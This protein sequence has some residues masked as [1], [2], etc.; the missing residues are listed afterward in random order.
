MSTDRRAFLLRT[1]GTLG[2]GALIGAGTAEAARADDAPPPAALPSTGAA[3]LDARFPFDGPHQ[4]GILTPQ[5]DAVTHLALDAIAADRGALIQGL[6]SLSARARELSQGTT[7]AP[8]LSDVDAPPADSGTLGVVVAPDALTVTIAFG[9]SLFDARYGLRDRR[10][11]ELIAMPAFPDDDL[12]P[13]RSHGDVLVTVAA[14]R[15]DTVVHAVREL[16]RPV[17]DA[18]ALRWTIDGFQSAD[19]AP[20][21][22]GAR[23]NLFGFRDGTANPDA[24]DEG[25]LV[26]VAGRA[27]EPAWTAGGTYTVLRVIRMHVEFWDRVGLR[28][29]ENMIGRRRDTGA[30]MGGDHERQDPRYDLDPKGDRVPLDAHIRM[31]NPRTAAT[32]PQ[33]IV[34]RAT[35]YSRGFDEAGQLDTGLLFVAHN[36]SIERQFAKIQARLAGEPMTDYV[37]PVGGGYFFAP[38]GAAGPSD[39]V[40][41][42][43]LA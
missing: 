40:G 29:Q 30:P 9:A 22:H 24:K 41:S 43:L 27:P 28:E 15:R 12:D 21:P 7:A 4:S 32:R 18:F 19:R 13:A 16:L 38:R 23:R 20:S 31:A 17:R 33:R 25:G 10:P 6:R 26:W 1:A 3:G 5:T 35:N 14:N 42:G 34:R 39:W 36:A 11:A 8:D 2:A 37:T